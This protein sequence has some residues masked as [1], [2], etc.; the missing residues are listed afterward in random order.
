MSRGHDLDKIINEYPIP[1][2][3]KMS[4]W[5]HEN[6]MSEK[7]AYFKNIAVASRVAYHGDEKAFKQFMESGKKQGLSR[8]DLTKLQRFNTNG[9]KN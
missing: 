4:Q 6:D 2:I 3:Q 5:A 1:L 7:E 9:R 8:K